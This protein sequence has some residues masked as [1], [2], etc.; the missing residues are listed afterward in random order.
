[1]VGWLHQLT[2]DIPT[3]TGSAAGWDGVVNKDGVRSVSKVLECD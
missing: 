1:M 3:I 2:Q